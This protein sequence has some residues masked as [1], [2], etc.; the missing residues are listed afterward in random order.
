MAAK[1]VWTPRARADVKKIYIDIG[2]HQP[3]SAER[4]FA[5]LRHKAQMLVE[6]PRLG[7]RQPSIFQTARMIIEAPYIILYETKPDADEGDV[8]MVEIVRVVDGRRD[9][10]SLFKP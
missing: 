2:R 10:S 7:T 4:Y 8:H 6:H 1:L 5:N 3:D 9:L